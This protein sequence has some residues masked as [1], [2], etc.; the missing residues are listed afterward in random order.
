MTGVTLASMNPFEEDN[1]G[2]STISNDAWM[3][4]SSLVL[5][6]PLS[7][8]Q[9]DLQTQRRLLLKTHR[10]IMARLD[11]PHYALSAKNLKELDVLKE[12]LEHCALDAPDTFRELL[13][14]LSEFQKDIRLTLDRQDDSREDGRSKRARVATSVGSSKSSKSSKRTATVEAATSGGSGGSGSDREHQNSL[15]QLGS[16]GS[17]LPPSGGSELLSEEQEQ[18]QRE[19]EQAAQPAAKRRRRRRIDIA[20]AI[21]ED[22][23]K[24]HFTYY[25]LFN[26]VFKSPPVPSNNNLLSRTGGWKHDHLVLPY[27]QEFPIRMSPRNYWTNGYIP[28]LEVF[29]K[30]AKELKAGIP[31]MNP[32]P[33]D[34]G[35]ESGMNDCIRQLAG[36]EPGCNPWDGSALQVRPSRPPARRPREWC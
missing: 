26:L 9:R 21:P 4:R 24:Q 18:Q 16:P 15:G 3:T 7:E 14:D 5:N 11:V 2:D 29:W 36:L 20:W 19:P 32:L 23:D 17:N 13:E 25:V 34:S 27:I 33:G 12:R 10:T 28:G 6:A 35:H 30:K 22:S 8:E 1:F 31:S